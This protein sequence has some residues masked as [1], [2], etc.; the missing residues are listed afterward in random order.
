MCLGVRGSLLLKPQSVS[1]PGAAARGQ[2]HVGQIA[3]H[4]SSPVKMAKL[5]PQERQT[6]P[7]ILASGVKPK[8]GEKRC[9]IGCRHGRHGTLVCRR[10]ALQG[11][12]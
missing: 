1:D 3:W 8:N 9:G 11:F 2:L 4:L 6:P 10:H 5:Q 12:S 7:R